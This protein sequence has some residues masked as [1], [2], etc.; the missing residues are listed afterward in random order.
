MR[1]L[2]ILSLLLLLFPILSANV[3]I[4]VYLDL[5]CVGQHIYIYHVQK[6]TTIND[7]AK[8]VPKIYAVIKNRQ[9]YHRAYVVEMECIISKQSISILID[10]GSNLRYVSHQVVEAC[11]L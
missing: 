1:I 9:E 11:A 4:I 8:N 5:F 7:A 3:C 10:P 2:S 6:A